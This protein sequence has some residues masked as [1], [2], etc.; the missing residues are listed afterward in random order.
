MAW[1]FLS[2][3]IMFKMGLRN[4]PRRG[5]Q[6]GLVVV[7]LMLATLIIT[8][9]FT[10]GDTIDFSVSSEAYSQLQRSD[11]NVKFRGEDSV[12]D[13]GDPAY[14]P[15]TAVS[16]LE[17]KFEGDE[18]IA[19]FLPFLSE[20]VATINQRTRLSE[21]TINL[22]GIDPNRLGALGGLRV[23]GGGKFDLST[24]GPDQVLLNETAAE[25][26]DARTGDTLTVFAN[27]RRYQATVA[28]V[29][30]DEL[31]SGSAGLF[32]PGGAGNV[33]GAVMQLAIV[34]RFTGH[35]DQID[36]LTVALNGGVRDSY[37][38]SD[39]AAP[40]L[41]SYLRSPEGKA[42]LALDYDVE[43]EKIK[44][45]AVAE[46]EE[47]G[48]LFTS[49]F[50]ILGMFSIAAGILLIFMIFVM[51]AAERKP[52]MG[53]SRAVGAQRSNLVQAFLAEGMAYNLI[54][55]A[56]G[57][58]LG[59]AA[60]IGLIVGFLKLSMGDELSF[61]T[62]KVTVQSLVI[63]Y[64]LGVVITF[65][66]VVIASIKVSSVNIVAAIRGTPED[67]T[68]EPRKKVSWFWMAIG[69]PAMIIP[70]L[71]IWFFFR[72]GLGLPWAWILA[73]I[74][75][76]LGALSIMAANSGGSEFLFSFGFCI[77]P[78]S[79]A[80]LA[81]Y[82]RAPARLT[83]TLVGLVLAAYWMAPINVGEKLLGRE[84]N[85]D[86]EM[87]VVSG[88]MTVVAFT[89]II[90]FNANL[91]TLLFKRNGHWKYRT[92][93]LLGAGTVAAAVIGFA[94]GD[95]GNG[96]GQLFYLVA[97]L[98]AIA[99]AV[100]FA[101]V[102][103]PGIA[104]ALKMGVA[105]PL[106]NRFRTGMT[107]AMFSLIIFSL[108][109]FSAVNANFIA[110]ISGD[111]GQDG[112]DVIATENRTYD[113][114]DLSAALDTA[115]APE[116]QQVVATGQVTLFTGEQQVRQG[117]AADWENYPVIAADD[118]FLGMPE[119]H[120]DS[121]ANGYDS[122][123]AAFDA[124]LSEPGLALLDWN[125][126]SDNGN[127][128]YDW[129]PDVTVKDDRF[130]PFQ[131][132][133]RNPTTGES[134]TVTVIGVLATKLGLDYVGGV[135]V[136]EDTY[137]PV[138]GAPDYRRTFVRLAPGS[139]AVVTAK[140]IEAALSTSGVQADSIDKLIDDSAA[141][142]RAF[143]RVFQAFMAL[144]LFVG[145]AALGVIA[146][147]SVVERRQ[148]IGMLRAIGYQSNSVALTFMLESTFVALMGILSGVV[149]GVVV[150]RN[151]FT[152]GQFSGEGVDF[153]MPWTEVAVFVIVAFAVSLFMTWWPSRSA[154]GVPVAEA[155]RYE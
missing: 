43:V 122:D 149:G 117:D 125:S 124:V 7:G 120:L 101:S 17:Q 147:R 23:V 139:D 36:A 137:K 86:I 38:S 115:G 110:M 141:M 79:A 46:A 97:I 67:E 142:D 87:F 90:V 15:E 106:S 153:A 29:V 145:V 75:F 134:S 16:T 107:I 13:A 113:V 20:P 51:L 77:I 127:G 92:P 109:V 151:L 72:K 62:G 58:A 3:R 44:Q 8:A 64:C 140:G 19:G 26:L 55:G 68:P 34:Q 111:T 76:M 123:R 135:Y 71:G 30:V 10:T 85:G 154:A 81:S 32:S 5:L 138:F 39:V 12:D 40:R 22:N 61:V 4:L 52:E 69:I 28:G 91:L 14:V 88:V 82:Y 42:L 66:T 104:P 98:L 1:I 148:Q 129:K 130:E 118:A 99:A 103:F 126:T 2:N 128:T 93:A 27:G 60:A 25:D 9:S 33:G 74:G 59:V 11:L 83:W 95:T 84:M 116:A 121:R 31:A 18:D 65:I 133:F 89:L 136:N 155:L 119:A 37:A 143:T 94:L 53:M 102:Q 6:T 35:R 152:V 70:P 150:S 41:E 24:L 45:D 105:Y 80:L 100:S 47:F 63:S 21:P 54:A 112:W 78:L 96:V 57:S 131:V 114:P 48:N 56:V 146:F 108:T 132:E 73:P 144:G 50:L 49:F